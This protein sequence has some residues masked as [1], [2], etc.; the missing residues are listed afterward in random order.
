MAKDGLLLL[1]CAGALIALGAEI[2]SLQ[3]TDEDRNQAVASALAIQTAMQQGRDFLQ[4]GDAKAAV[5]VLEGQ[6]SR[7]NGNTTYLALLRDAY[8]AYLKELRLANQ[9]AEVQRYQQRLQILDP[10]AGLDNTLARLASTSPTP[11]AAPVPVKAPEPAKAEPKVRGLS[12]DD[13]PF[14]PAAAL[15]VTP[16][17]PAVPVAPPPSPTAALL[18]RAEEA[19]AQRQYREAGALFDQAYQSDPASTQN[20]RERW[21]YCKLHTVVEKLNQVPPGAPAGADLEKEARSALELCPK[22]EFAKTVLAEIDKRRGGP[23]AAGGTPAGAVAVQHYPRGSEGWARAETTNFRIFHN[24]SREL[25]E[26]VAQVAEQT[27]TDMLRKWM[28]GA[29]E[30]WK[31]RCDLFLHATAQDYSRVTGV[32]PKSP[33]H[34][35]IQTEG[36]RVLMRRIDL[37]C[38]DPKNLVS[39]VLPHETTHV[40]L[41]GQVGDQPVPRWAD[42]GIAVLTEPRD[43]VDR[44]LQNLARSRQENG[45]FTVRQLMEMADYPEPRRISAYYAQSVSLV[46]FLATQK[47]PQVFTQFLREAQK[48]GYEQALQKHYGFKNFEELQQRWSQQAFAAAEGTSSGVAQVGR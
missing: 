5:F 43:K 7:I 12:E 14:R 9:A 42:E 44:H 15:K 23:P 8:R 11:A 45:L 26:Q 3:A 39:A 22:L 33:G 37:H 19:F 36:T 29:K 21:A 2:T 28:G 1:V 30:D 31:P 48:I 20:A 32:P 38:D 27:R 4:R 6:L 13:D 17:K 46:D 34:S 40:V 18:A 35:S 24:Q 25:A 47:G 10:G 16:A 41:A